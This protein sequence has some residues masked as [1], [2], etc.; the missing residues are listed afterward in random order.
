MIYKENVLSSNG[1]KWYKVW[2]KIEN[3]KIVNMGCECLGFQKNNK[4]SLQEFNQPA[5]K[6]GSPLC[7]HLTYLLQRLYLLNKTGKLKKCL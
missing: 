4:K 1:K 6:S 2:A 7:K 5:F 3:N